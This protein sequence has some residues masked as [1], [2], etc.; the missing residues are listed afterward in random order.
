MVQLDSIWEVIS[1]EDIFY[2]YSFDVLNGILSYWDSCIQNPK[3][4]DTFYF[5]KEN[6]ELDQVEKGKQRK[7]NNCEQCPGNRSCNKFPEMK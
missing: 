5:K 4:F 1:S 7:H 6:Y 3:Y 2:T